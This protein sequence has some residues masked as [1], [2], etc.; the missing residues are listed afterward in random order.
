[1]NRAFDVTRPC[2]VA[3]LVLAT[4]SWTA[5]AQDTQR[6]AAVVNDDV[7][8]TLDLAERVELVVRTTG[9][10]DNQESRER[11]RPQVMRTLIDER[12]QIQ[13]AARL[14]VELLPGD[15]DGAVRFLER[16]NNVPEGKMLEILESRGVPAYTLLNQLEAEL[17]WARLVQARVHRVVSITD[18]DVDEVLER[19]A[20]SQ[21]KPEIRLAE[22]FLAAADPAQGTEVAAAAN[23][24][25]EDIRAGANFA[26]LA[27]QFSQSASARTGGDLGWTLADQ[28]AEDV[29]TA[30]GDAPEGALIG[31]VAA[32]GGYTIMLVVGRRTFGQ[33]DV[34]DTMLNLE[35][36]ALPLPTVVS[37]AEEQEQL[38]R[39]RAAASRI[40]G[41]DDAEAAAEA[42]PTSRHRVIGDYRLGDLVPELRTAVADLRP[43]GVSAPMVAGGV[44]SILV[45]CDRREPTVTEPTRDEIRESLLSQRTELISHGYLRDLRRSA[46]LDVRL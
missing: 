20:A 17:K 30:V 19:R 34:G 44:I 45:V 18:A 24:M 15:V 31:P 13:E 16:Q 5:A 23:R 29:A 37:E 36:V 3:L 46:F 21:G 10:A 22:I 27:R 39:A 42:T 7:I 12:L 6:I 32:R 4:W 11:I 43:G 14:G 2:L 41:C 9:L 33:V 28:L 26:A 8:S 38:A 25:V 1:M 35:L 40:T